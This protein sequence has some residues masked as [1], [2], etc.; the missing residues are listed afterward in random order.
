[1]SSQQPFVAQW[2]ILGC[3]WIS[4]EFTKDIS[5][6]MAL[7]NVTDVSHAIAAV[8][9]RS[10][11]KA[12]DFISKYCPNGAAGQQDGLVDFKPKAY[13]SYKGVVEDP[14]SVSNESVDTFNRLNVRHRM[15]TLCM[16][17][18]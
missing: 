2:G 7:R 17:V 14:V 15:S 18:L 4:S 6:P 9:S 1:M 3:G 10:L 11:S 16:W 5:R 12:E 13:G 8:G